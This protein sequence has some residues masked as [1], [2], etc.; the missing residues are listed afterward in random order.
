M[1]ANYANLYGHARE[2]SASIEPIIQSFDRR[3]SLRQGIPAPYTLVSNPTSTIRPVGAGL[4]THS[5]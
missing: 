1:N 5:G 2:Q 4:E 3:F